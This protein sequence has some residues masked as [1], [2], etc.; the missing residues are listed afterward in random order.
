MITILWPEMS[1]NKYDTSLYNGLLNEENNSEKD[2]ENEL[3]KDEVD[4]S[5]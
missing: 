5:N 3:I 2:Y 4:E 1:Y